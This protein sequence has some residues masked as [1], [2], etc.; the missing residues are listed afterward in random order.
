MPPVLTEASTIRCAHEGTVVAQAGH[1]G[2][3]VGGAAVLA[4]GDLLA[5]R[6]L[7]CRLTPP[8]TPCAQI[9]TIDAGVSGALTVGGRP[10]LLQTAQGTT[11]AGTWLVVDPGQTKLEAT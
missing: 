6:I 3:T 1:R 9:I 4:D 10:V 8:A 11:N 5:A 7:G 2:L